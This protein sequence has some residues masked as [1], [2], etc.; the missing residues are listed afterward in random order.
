[1][2][3]GYFEKVIRMKEQTLAFMLAILM[4]VGVSG[5]K[6]EKPEPVS[7]HLNQ[8][9]SY[10]EVK[11]VDGNTYATIQIGDQTWMAENLR[12]TRYSNGDSIPNIQKSWEWY[13]RTSDAW[14]NYNNDSM[15]DAMHGRLYNWYTVA[16]PRN[17]C[18]TGWHVPSDA[19]LTELINYL[20]GP[21]QAGPK[22][23][24]TFPGQW[25]GNAEATNESG[26]SVLP[27]GKRGLAADFTLMTYRGTFWSAT[28][29]NEGDGL[30][31]EIFWNGNE[32]GRYNDY[33]YY[34]FSVRCVKD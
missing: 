14:S 12:T 32:V 16:D 24:S 17:L 27:S 22:M 4:L 20:G 6:K 3:Q 34:G 18:P 1:M 11:D 9:L 15:L 21:E 13:N 31:R 28:E 7:T 8:D 2:T 26:L 29:Y 5:C 33:K 30:A 23:K 25:S 10:G 19:D